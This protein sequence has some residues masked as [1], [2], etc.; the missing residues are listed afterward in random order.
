MRGEEVCDGCGAPSE[1][2]ERRVVMQGARS[3]P[4][5]FPSHAREMDVGGVGTI[6]AGAES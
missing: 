2:G 3:D 4:A 1:E 6:V 5:E